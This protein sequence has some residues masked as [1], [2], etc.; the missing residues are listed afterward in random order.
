M[1]KFKTIN[2]HGKQYVEVSE[3]IKYFRKEY[4]GWSLTSDFVELTEKRCVIKSSIKNPDGYEIATGVAY[5]TEG[6]TFINKT[7][8]IENCETSAN[9]RALSNFGIGIDTGIASADEVRNAIDQKTPSLKEKVVKIAEPSKL[10]E[11]KFKA[12]LKAL[13]QGKVKEV[14]ARL[15]KYE[16]SKS[17]ASII[18]QIIKTK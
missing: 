3:K 2:I 1:S 11:D 4:K 6:S 14:K 12:I 7:S 9:G 10:P 17:Q 16:L 18:N 13:E 8:F 5:E 15:P